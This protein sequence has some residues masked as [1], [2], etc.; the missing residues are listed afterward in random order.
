LEDIG[1]D[2][3]IILS[4]AFKK[5]DAETCAGLIRLRRGN[6]VGC[7]ES[8]DEPSVSI[9]FGIVLTS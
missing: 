5:L 9:D 1:V 3:T 6:V 7:C 8:G 4:S 2:G